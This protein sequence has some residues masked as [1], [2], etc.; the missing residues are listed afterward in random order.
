MIYVSYQKRCN[1]TV[2]IK[3]SVHMKVLLADNHDS[4]VYNIVQILRESGKAEVD[5]VLTDQISLDIVKNYDAIVFSPGP[6][7]VDPGGKM[8]AILA[9][10]EDDM[11]VLG[12]CLGYDV[13]AQYFGAK[14]NNLN[15]NYHGM[16]RKVHILENSDP[17]FSGLPLSIDVGL[18]HS[19]EVDKKSLT[20]Q[21]I[22]CAVSEDRV[23]MA[24]RHVDRPVYGVQFH[25]ESIMTPQGEKLL[26]NFL[27]IAEKR[28]ASLSQLS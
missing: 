23:L 18:Y 3:K 17:L 8:T 14:L 24:V 7:I 9:H 1:F 10:V 12:I 28:R 21:L 26:L 19:W 11:P 27:K 2:P 20:P 25:P 16:K 4:F 5:V 15:M 13:I 22:R 6:D